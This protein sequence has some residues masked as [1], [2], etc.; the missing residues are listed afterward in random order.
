[1]TLNKALACELWGARNALRRIAADESDY[2]DIGRVC[3]LSLTLR[4]LQTGSYVVDFATSPAIAIVDEVIKTYLQATPLED[5]QSRLNWL[6]KKATEAAAYLH[7]CKARG[8][9]LE[10]L[11]REPSL[12]AVAARLQGEVVDIEAGKYSFRDLY[13]VVTKIG[14]KVDTYVSAENIAAL[15]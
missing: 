10:D 1:M 15:A 11:G 4:A 14:D 9:F 6:E 7:F 5:V 3:S 2:T 12:T 13:A 8:K